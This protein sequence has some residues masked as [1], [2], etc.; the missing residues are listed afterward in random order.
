MA[1][2]EAGRASRAWAG[3]ILAALDM[4]NAELALH[5]FLLLAAIIGAC[6]LMGVVA[7]KLGQAQVIAEMVD[8]L[9]ARALALRLAGART[10][11][12]GCSAPTAMPSVYGL[13]QIALTLYMFTVGLEFE[14]TLL[15]RSIR[16]AAAVSLAGILAPF[17]LGGGAGVLLHSSRRLLQRVDDAPARPALFLGAS[18]SITAFPMLARILQRARP[19]RARRS[20]RLALAAGAMGDVAAWLIFADRRRQLQGRRHRSRSI[21]FAGAVGY[22]ARGVRARSGRGLRRLARAGGRSRRGAARRRSAPS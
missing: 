6:K 16:Q 14:A 7:R 5:V 1:D 15:Q 2:A 12:P 10:R 13:A 21:A 19:D 3:S 9:P 22:A 4:S 8:G 20:A 18:L 17:A 11:R